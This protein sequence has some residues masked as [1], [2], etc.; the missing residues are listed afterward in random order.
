M[1]Y[2]WPQMSAIKVLVHKSFEFGDFCIWPSL[3]V[4]HGLTRWVSAKFWERMKFVVFE[5]WLLE[6]P[7]N[8]PNEYH[9][10][11]GGQKF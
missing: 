9:K 11:L 3:A 2:K 5:I 8:T 6:R 4:W 1:A 7:L 10:S